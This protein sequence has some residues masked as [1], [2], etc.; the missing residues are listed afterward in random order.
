MATG[1]IV[2]KTTKRR[3]PRKSAGSE[4]RINDVIESLLSVSGSNLSG[5]DAVG[6]IVASLKPLVPFEAATVY[7]VYRERGEMQPVHDEGERVEMLDF[8]SIGSGDGLTGWSAETAKPVLLADRTRMSSYHPD[9][10]FASFLSVPIAINDRVVA[11][12]NFGARKA[13][14]FS[15]THAANLDQLSLP[16]AF[17]LENVFLKEDLR[18]LEKS[19]ADIEKSLLQSRD[20]SAAV[21]SLMTIIDLATETNHIVNEALSV[22]VGN[23]QCLLL[24]NAASNQ[25]GIARLRRVEQAAMNVNECN[26]KLLRIAALVEKASRPT[27]QE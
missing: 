8:V 9:T 26:R 6:E 21:Q 19:R 18:L 7:R 23:V 16:L 15:K 2:K 12:L 5:A 11:I 14:G 13:S 25:K 1:S 27:R 20:S 4:K 24:E 10:D 22:I 3:T 17:S